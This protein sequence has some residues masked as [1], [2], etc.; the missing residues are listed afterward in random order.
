[1]RLSNTMARTGRAR[2]DG[3]TLMELMLTIALASVALGFAVPM[4]QSLTANNRL[5]TQANEFVALTNFARSEAI[6]RN[7]AIT[8]C[9]A[10]SP[11]ATEC[12]TDDEDW[13]AWI[14]VNEAGDVLRAGEVN[15]YGGR[16][17]VTSDLSDQSITFQSDG[18]ARTAGALV[19]DKRMWVCTTQNVTENF[20]V[21]TFGAG[22]RISMT[23]TGDDCP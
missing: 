2:A 21:L 5:I 23:R 12:D 22:S 1:M 11:A 13:L 7:S 10:E 19:V 20:R 18:L 15:T 9:R 4:F 14:M 16:I 6:T 17:H 8:L 3:F